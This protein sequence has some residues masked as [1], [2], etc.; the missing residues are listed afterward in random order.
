[1][2]RQARKKSETG[3]YHLITKGNGGQILFYDRADHLFYLSLL[4]R[5]SREFSVIVHA[6]CLMNNHVHLIVRDINGNISTFMRKIDTAYSMFFNKKYE[7][8]GHVFQDR[9]RSEVISSDNYL[10]TSFRYV[11]NNPQK[12][13][14]CSAEEYEWNSFRFYGDS[15]SFV[16][17]GIFTE[18]IGS[19]DEYRAFIAGENDDECMEFDSGKHDDEWGSKIIQK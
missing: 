15:T 2:P 5:F 13:G 16:D 4:E 1:M 6:Y 14:I 17:T 9:F 10:L 18:L 8:S 19:R 12:A 7:R 11:L 3:L